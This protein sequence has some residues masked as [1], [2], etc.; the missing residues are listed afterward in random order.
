MNNNKFETERIFI[1]E[2]S[3]EDIDDQVMSWFKDEELMRFYTS[4]KKEITKNDLIA[5]IEAGRKD[6]NL[7]TFG[8]FTK[9][10]NRLIGTLKLGPVHKIHKTSDLVILIGDRNYLGKGLAV[11]AIQLGNKV[12]FEKFDIRRLQG[13]MYVSNIP[14]IKA[15]TRAGW[16]IEGRLKGY[17]QVDGHNEDRILVSCLNPKY[18]TKEEILELREQEDRYGVTFKK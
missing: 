12:A 9:E 3:V 2:I 15:Y 18:F 16:I 4:S 10:N 7:I 13:G 17:Y 1:Q 6:E 14:S 11:E 5:S 8:L